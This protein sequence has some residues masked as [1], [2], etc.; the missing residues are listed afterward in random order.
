[1]SQLPPSL[2]LSEAMQQIAGSLNTMFAQVRE[3]FADFAPVF[4]QVLEHIRALP[5]ATR[6]GLL[7]LG[8]HGWYVDPEL[9]AGILLHLAGSVAEQPEEV[10]R[11]LCDWIDT[12][13]AD[14]EAQ[15]GAAH[16]ERARILA[17]AFAAHR[18]HQYALSIPVFLAQADGI[19]QELMGVQLFKKDRDTREP[20][21]RKEAEPLDSVSA[22]M[23]TPLINTMPIMYG[24]QKREPGVLNRH[25][26]LHG[27]S[28][29]YDTRENSCRAI[30]LIGYVSWALAINDD[31][32]SD[33]RAG[34]AQVR[35]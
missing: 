25:A 18:A 33:P 28:T 16:P 26:V 7:A 13:L 3:I 23:L 22:L 35:L 31:K 20:V 6:N 10:T 24:P 12:R 4:R 32:L 8:R 14:Y 27:E 17:Q 15:L 19:C 9:P 5:E 34:G 1:M 30:S 29:D 21:L 2:S 11:T